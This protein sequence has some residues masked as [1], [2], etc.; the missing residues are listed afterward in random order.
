MLLQQ[1]EMDKDADLVQM[2]DILLTWSVSVGEL[3]YLNK[4]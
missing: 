4:L 1:I 3:I 2:S